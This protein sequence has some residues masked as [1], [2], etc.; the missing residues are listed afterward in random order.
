MEAKIKYAYLQYKML[1]MP[2]KSSGIMENVPF[3]SSTLS[4]IKIAMIDVNAIVICLI[5]S[6]KSKTDDILLKHRLRKEAHRQAIPD[7]ASIIWFQMVVGGTKSNSSHTNE[8][9]SPATKLAFQALGTDIWK[10][11]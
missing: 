7:K 9:A 2:T 4:I 8:K 11:F 1:I 3:R 5:I 6:R 10:E